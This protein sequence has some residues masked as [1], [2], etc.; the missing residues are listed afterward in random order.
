M[1]SKMN[2]SEPGGEER[3]ALQNAMWIHALPFIAWIVIMWLW[4][5]PS[6]TGYAVRTGIGLALL[7]YCQP[8]RWYSPLK[9]SHLPAAI[10]VGGA[11]FIIWV[12][13]ETPFADRI[14]YFREIYDRFFR[15]PV[16]ALPE[17][18]GPSP[19]HPLECGWVLTGMRLFGSAVVIATIE[20]FFWRGF[21]YRWMLQPNFLKVPLNTFHLSSLLLVALVFATAH[22][23][24]LV[25]FITGILYCLFM[26][27]TRD[28]WAVCIAHG[29]TNLLLGLYV[30]WT[31]SYAFW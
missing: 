2:P 14:P 18:A 16:W 15:W 30:I 5:P 21:L 24:I 28:I 4:T 31:D 26:I 13:P 20:E 12:A 8:W 9:L 7:L 22:E 17:D 10:L 3:V 25:A 1:P 29:V 11:V 27:R 23:R 6:A 19:Y